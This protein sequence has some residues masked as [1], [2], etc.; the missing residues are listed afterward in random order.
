MAAGGGHL[1]LPRSQQGSTTGHLRPNLVC[2]TVFE[3]YGAGL[4][5]ASP[6][7][8]STAPGWACAPCEGG[9]G[10]PRRGKGTSSGPF[11][12]PLPPD[13]RSSKHEWPAFVYCNGLPHTG[14]R[15]LR[16]DLSWTAL[17]FI[18][19]PPLGATTRTA[20]ASCPAADVLPGRRDGDRPGGA[21]A[22]GHLHQTL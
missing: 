18:T 7:S 6:S 8:S 5:R 15:S 22:R 9:C 13:A 16:A 11:V 4:G 17:L 1:R 20:S 19:G 21:R 3:F 10:P 12:H 2:F 14:W